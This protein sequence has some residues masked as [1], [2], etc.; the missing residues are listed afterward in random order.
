MD[1]DEMDKKEDDGRRMG[2]SRISLSISQTMMMTMTMLTILIT[3]EDDDHFTTIT[4]TLNEHLLPLR[5][6]NPRLPAS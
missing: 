5:E 4:S 6:S 1:K 2:T 3:M